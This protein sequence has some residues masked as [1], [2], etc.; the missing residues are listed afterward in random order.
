LPIIGTDATVIG[1]GRLGRGLQARPAARREPSRPAIVMTGSG[2]RRWLGFYGRAVGERC[3][4]GGGF[5]FGIAGRMSALPGSGRF[6]WLRTCGPGFHRCGRPDF[7]GRND[8]AGFENFPVP[9]KVVFADA[10]AFG[11]RQR[12]SPRTV[13]S[14]TGNPSAPRPVVD[15]SI[16]SERPTSSSSLRFCF[17]SS[18]RPFFQGDFL[19]G[20]ELGFPPRPIAASR[21]SVAEAEIRQGTAG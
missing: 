19:G 14:G 21:E 15:F 4:L 5:R 2:L 10:R 9:G 3:R 11:L 16:F 20:F 12:S 18:R 8:L 6:F 17:S 1:F 7:T 13:G